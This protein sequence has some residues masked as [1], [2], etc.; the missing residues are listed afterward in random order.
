MLPLIVLPL[1]IPLL[2]SAVQATG[3]VLDG[4]SLSQLGSWGTILIAFDVLFITMGW[5]AF[6]IIS[7]D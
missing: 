5:L 2:I 1:Q 3:L 6:E 7:V 4:Q